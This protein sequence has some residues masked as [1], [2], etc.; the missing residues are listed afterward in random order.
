MINNVV[1]QRILI[2][3]HKVCQIFRKL[4]QLKLPYLSLFLPFSPFLRYIWYENQRQISL[5]CIILDQEK[6]MNPLW[7]K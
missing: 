6:W 7:I 2:L 4:G 3:I 5:Y 1:R